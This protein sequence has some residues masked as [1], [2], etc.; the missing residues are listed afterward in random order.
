MTPYK[1]V[2][3]KQY[4]IGANYVGALLPDGPPLGVEPAADNNIMKVTPH[5]LFVRPADGSIYGGRR[6]M[7]WWATVIAVFVFF[8]FSG[9]EYG[10]YLYD[11]KHEA[12]AGTFFDHYLQNWILTFGS[13]IFFFLACAWLFIPW[14]RQLPI[15]FN[16]QTGKVTTYI[17]GRGVSADWQNL[18]AYCKD[19]TSFVASGVAVNEGILTLGFERD[20]QYI[21]VYATQ[22]SSRPPGS[23]RIYGA[24]QLW[25]Y[26]RLYMQK[27]CWSLPP[28][29]TIAPYRIAHAHE[30]VRQFNPLKALRVRHP[31][32]LVLAVPFFLFV[33][34]PTAPLVMLGDIIYMWLD[35]I[36]PRRKWPQELIDACDGVWNG[37]EE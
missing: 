20:G 18:Q 3:S 33:A 10:G 11:V 13:A 26:I 37:R 21:G 7:S 36:L 23:R 30:A 15:I 28:T 8:A 14:R 1:Q 4:G 34:L 6:G 5:C 9:V 19:A 17:K 24:I 25:A 16:R 35:H 31:A 27:G 32:W 29:C 2:D 22:D 12:Y